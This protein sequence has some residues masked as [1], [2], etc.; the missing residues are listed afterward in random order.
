MD[1]RLEPRFT[2]SVPTQATVL[3]IRDRELACL[4]VETSA[5]GMKLLSDEELPQDAII[6]LDFEFHFV[7]AVI[8]HS[9]SFGG[10]YAMGA[11]RILAVD[12]DALRPGE[13][14]GDQMRAWLAEKGWSLQT[15]TVC[16]VFDS[17]PPQVAME[18]PPPEIRIPPPPPPMRTPPPPSRSRSWQVPLAVAAS[19]AIATLAVGY[20]LQFGSP[21]ATATL[22][23]VPAASASP[24]DMKVPEPVAAVPPT[25]PGPASRVQVKGL[26]TT[27]VAVTADGRAV[28]GQLLTD[29]DTREFEF[30]RVLHVRVGAAGGVEISFN[31]KPLG[32]LGRPGQLRLIEFTPKEFRFLPWTDIDQ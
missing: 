26:S 31:G 12:K 15:E 6:G 5:F 9:Y 24:V 22:R 21:A 13:S 4:L 8:R 7:L 1:R 25:A 11:E 2:L 18:P 19:L 16:S 30:A 3:G 10:K 23:A 32:S 20:V 14:R 29:G 27:W 28:L 17:P